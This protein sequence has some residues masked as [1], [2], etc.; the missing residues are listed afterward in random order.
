[1]KFLV[2]LLF[3][4][5]SASL[6]QEYGYCKFTATSKDPGITGTATFKLTSGKL[7]IDVDIQGITQNLDNNHGM[8]IHEFGDISD[9]SAGASAGSHWNPLNSPHAC[10][11]TIT[12]HY[13]DTGNWMVAA[14][15]TLKAS[16]TLDLVGLTGATSVIGHAFVLHNQTDD[17]A[18]V[19]SSGARLAF[20]VIGV[21]NVT[22]IGG[23]TNPAANGEGGITAAVCDLATLPGTG[24]P[25]WTVTGRVYFS[26][27]GG[28]GATTVTA[29]VSGITGP[30]GFHIHQWGDM[31]SLDGLAVGGH[32][33]PD[34]NNHS[35]PTIDKRHLGDMGN[36]YYEA[37]G[38]SY[39]KFVN[40]K[41]S[42]N[43]VNNVIGRAV[44]VHAAMDNCSST[45]NGFAGARWAQCI[46]GVANKTAAP[47]VIDANTPATQDDTNCKSTGTTTSANT[48]TDTNA[49]NS[50][51]A[52]T[53]IVDGVFHVFALFA[54]AVFQSFNSWNAL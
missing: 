19:A 45:N 28:S 24:T 29:K 9:T 17:C 23:T 35:F 43:G 48:N 1:M 18:V 50:S 47:L 40:D 4:V 32:Y 14:D 22:R 27:P 12:R 5:I 39:Y 44:I 34:N 41:I 11:D 21:G 7:T 16:K 13:G 53:L 25:T 36:I 51:P 37:G 6:A 38:Y 46:I 49:E 20:C 30:H 3:S 2:V 15:G 8:H 33:N 31:G 26:Q 10:E 54:V 52:S 42:L